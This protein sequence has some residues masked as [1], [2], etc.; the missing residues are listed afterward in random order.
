MNGSDFKIIRDMATNNKLSFI[1]LSEAN[2]VSGGDY[3][4]MN[5]STEHFTN[6]DEFGYSLFHGCKKLE[7]IILPKTIE[8]IGQTAFWYCSNLTSLVIYSKVKIIKPGIWGG[9][10][11]LND[12]KIIDNSNFHFENNILYDKNYTKIIAALSTGFYGDLTIKEGIKEIQYHSFGDCKSL[13]SVIFPST[14]TK[15]GGCSFS[16]SRLTSI[17]F[18]K[19]IQT[20]DSFAFSGCDQLKEV[21]LIEVKIKTLEYGTFS[22]CKLETVYLPKQLETMKQVVFGNNPLK[23]IFCY[24]SNPSDL[25]DFSTDDATFKNVDIKECIVHV[26]EGKIN[27]YKEAKGWSSFNSIID[28][29][30]NFFGGFES[31]NKLDISE[32]YNGKTNKL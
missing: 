25:F 24:S 12:V 22:Y 6:N 5:Y 32:N 27:I 11:K 15:I 13:T 30:E 14:L 26:P 20:I 1:D 31:D 7:K 9:C 10:D 18:N 17:I 29:S 21:N 2:I 3:Y 8:E 4:Y 16:H 19:N 23:N 28:D